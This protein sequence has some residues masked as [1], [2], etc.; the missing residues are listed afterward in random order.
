M[1]DQRGEDYLKVDDE[2]AEEDD[3]TQR[4]TE[5]EILD[6]QSSPI[7]ERKWTFPGKEKLFCLDWNAQMSTRPPFVASKLQRVWNL[8]SYF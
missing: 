2:L 3:R 1:I 4:I 5:K 8:W 7:R 6:V